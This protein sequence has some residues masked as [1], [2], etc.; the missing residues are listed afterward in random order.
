MIIV[1]SQQF[2]VQQSILRD[3]PAEMSYDVTGKF[4]FT[5]SIKQA[6]K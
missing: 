3:S 1:S 4:F 2:S 6:I 5:L